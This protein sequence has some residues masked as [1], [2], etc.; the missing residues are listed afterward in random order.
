MELLLN[1]YPVYLSYL[2]NNRV[3]HLAAAVVVAEVKVMAMKNQVDDYR[4][5]SVHTFDFESLTV[6]AFE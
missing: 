5:H 4:M 3:E 1:L 2:L 6:V